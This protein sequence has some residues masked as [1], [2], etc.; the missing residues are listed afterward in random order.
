MVQLQ[1]GTS[2]GSQTLMSA[3]EQAHRGAELRKVYMEFDLTGSGDVGADE[4]LLLG[5]TRR[6]LGQK[7]GEWTEEMNNSLMSKIG[8]DGTGNFLSEENFIKYFAGISLFPFLHIVPSL[9]FAVDLLCY[10]RAPVVV[11][12]E[13]ALVNDIVLP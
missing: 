12:S 11:S 2:S 8:A 6:K 5:R 10:P 4:L 9:H 7:D 1:V 3:A 13:I